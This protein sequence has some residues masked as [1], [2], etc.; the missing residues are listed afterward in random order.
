V[1]KK[2]AKADMA[3]NGGG[4]EEIEG[5][6]PKCLKEWKGEKGCHPPIDKFASSQIPADETV[7]CVICYILGSPPENT[8][9]YT[10]PSFI[11]TGLLPGGR[12]IFWGLGKH[13]VQTQ[14]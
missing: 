2:F 7:G 5:A 12:F 3:L 6:N 1:K 8:R 14:L 10:S 9:K 4:R 13:P 11:K